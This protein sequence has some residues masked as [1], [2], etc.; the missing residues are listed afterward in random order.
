MEKLRK[1]AENQSK[2]LL[3]ASRYCAV[4]GVLVYSTCSIFDDENFEVVEKFLAE[5]KNF[6]GI[7]WEN[8]FSA[9][10]RNRLESSV[11]I[12]KK[13]GITLYD[14]AISKYGFYLHK[15]VRNSW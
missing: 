14:P 5:N 1:F 8:C 13:G 3:N 12:N 10:V 7:G 2:L 11:K 9:A 6:V 4:G 15:L